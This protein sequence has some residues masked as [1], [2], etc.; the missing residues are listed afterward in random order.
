MTQS[1]LSEELMSMQP[2]EI[3]GTV[4][5][6]WR[7]PVKSMQGERL[8]EAI[9]GDAGVIGDRAYAVVDRKTG[10][11]A[12]A[13]H[14][15]LWPDLLSCRAT[16]SKPPRLGE[17]LPAVR[18]DL[19]DGTSVM[20][21]AD[22]VDEV[23]SRFFGRDVEL[24]RSAPSDFTIDQY[25]PDIENL[26]PEG[27]RDE[28]TDTKLGAALFSQLGMPSFVPEGSFMDMF[29][30]SVMTTSTL[31]RLGELQ[32]ESVADIRRFRM[33]L[34]VD[35]AGTGFVENDWPGKTIGVGSEV[36]LAVALPDP[37]CVMS[38]AAQPGLPHDPGIL[39]SLAK[40]NRIDVAGAGLYPCAGAY[41]LTAAA[42]T[43]RTA[44]PVRI[45]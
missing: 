22:D 34:L 44:D 37:R 25:H 10:K 45:F 14:P 29:P 21:D 8:D 19:T 24:A 30:V 12:S 42:G 13:K 39:R 36:Q 2:S 23:L 28:V 11:V 40:H 9:V 17:D 32:P 43:V 4:S 5:E 35:T 3:V 16:F 6:L 33:N 20:S 31:N 26:D 41:A 38:T 27:H 18:I 7:F 1:G 15:K